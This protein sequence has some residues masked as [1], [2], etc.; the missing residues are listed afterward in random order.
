MVLFQ[1]VESI[2]RFSQ[3]IG[4]GCVGATLLKTRRRINYVART[5][6]VT[7]PFSS[8]QGLL[9]QLLSLKCFLVTPSIETSV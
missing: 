7:S 3:Q 8:I 6:A 4:R 2:T 5:F 9:H 1:R